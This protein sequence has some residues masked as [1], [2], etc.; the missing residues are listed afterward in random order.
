MGGS[1]KFLQYLSDQPSYDT[2][3]EDFKNFTFMKWVNTTYF[4]TPQFV[5]YI[6]MHAVGFSYINLIN[7]QRSSAFLSGNNTYLDILVII[8]IS[9]ITFF[10]SGT[11]TLRN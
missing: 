10:L 5:Y 6:V 9:A 2:Q 8:P 11:I 3:S 4:A 7:L 1:Y